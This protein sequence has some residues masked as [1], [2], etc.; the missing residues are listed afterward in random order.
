M[1]HSELTATLERAHQPPIQ[2]I[3]KPIQSFIKLETSGGILL[4]LCTVVALVWAN[5]PWSN[6]YTSLWQTPFTIG[7]GEFVLNKAFILWIN[8]GLMAIFFFVVGLE[9]K[10]NCC[11]GSYRLFAKQHCRL[12]LQ[13]AEWSFPPG[14]IF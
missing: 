9:I 8:D 1:A 10:R 6:S 2:K 13:L 12:R 14:F 4:L 11:L 5:S 3:L 7:F